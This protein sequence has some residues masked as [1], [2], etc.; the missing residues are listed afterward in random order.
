MARWLMVMSKCSNV[1]AIK[2]RYLLIIA[3]DMN[4]TE[5]DFCFKEKEKKIDSG[6]ARKSSGM[7]RYS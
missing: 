1:A 5:N 6:T 4:K 7:K 3:G 2:V